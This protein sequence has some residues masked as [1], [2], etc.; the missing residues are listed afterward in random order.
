MSR[1]QLRDGLWISHKPSVYTQ[2]QAHQWLQRINH[3]NASSP[4]PASFR[5]SLEE[6]SLLMRL[7]LTTFPFE[8]TAMHYTAEHTM[9]ISYD[10]LFHRL[11]AGTSAGS[12]AGSWCYGLNRLFFQM[13]RALGFRVYSGSGRINPQPA[14]EAPNFHAFV[15]MVVFVQPVEGSN[16]TYVADVASGLVSPILLA[17]G[18]IVEGTSPTE[19]HR[20]I[21]AGRTDSSL[22]ISPDALTPAN[23]EWRLEEIRDSKEPNQPPSTRVMYAFLEDEFFEED[24]R[25]GN[26]HVLSLPDGLFVE[27]VLCT[28]F[29][30]LSDEEIDAR[31]EPGR[32]LGR[33]ALSG[34][35]VR[36]HV[37]LQTSVLREL[38][39]EAERAQALEEYFGLKIQPEALRHIWGRAA[40]LAS[41]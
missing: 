32:Y 26:Q 9:D 30:F 4:E 27:N 33:I 16:V 35:V 31:W 12:G 20:L 11:V 25:A 7:S 22:R 18:E 6:L 13:L 41:E 19:R 29:F 21:R 2:S 39:T 14:G 36:R 28:K 24:L 8:N 23:V 10:G 40:A 3:P 38:R 37:G 34:N 17:D 15:H 1:G 5:P